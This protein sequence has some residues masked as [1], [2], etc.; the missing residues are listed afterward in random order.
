MCLLIDKGVLVIFTHEVVVIAV[1]TCVQLLVLF[2][3]LD[4]VD[5]SE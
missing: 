2:L 3:L 1:G 5:C 4:A